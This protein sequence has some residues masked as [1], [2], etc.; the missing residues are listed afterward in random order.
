L[1]GSLTT[2]RDPDGAVPTTEDRTP[3]LDAT[4]VPPPKSRDGTSQTEPYWIVPGTMVVV[5]GAHAVGT[6]P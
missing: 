2:T 6:P 3:G 5:P 4:T 1:A